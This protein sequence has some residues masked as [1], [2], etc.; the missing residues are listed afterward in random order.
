MFGRHCRSAGG[1][2]CR[3]LRDSVDALGEVASQ[4][5]EVR[6]AMLS[7]LRDLHRLLYVRACRQLELTMFVTWRGPRNCNRPA[8]QPFDQLIWRVVEL[9]PEFHTSV[10]GL[11]LPGQ[12]VLPT[13]RWVKMEGMVAVAPAVKVV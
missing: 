5:L 6:R 11:Y 7:V 2:C 9:R 13:S 12:S 8:L 1:L 4:P 3:R 10:R